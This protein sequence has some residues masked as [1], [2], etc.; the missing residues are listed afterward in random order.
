MVQKAHRKSFKGYLPTNK[1][2]ANILSSQSPEK[3][4]WLTCQDEHVAWKENTE[5]YAY[6]SPE[7]GEKRLCQAM[8]IAA[9]NDVKLGD[10]HE[11]LS[12]WRYIEDIVPGSDE[13]LLSFRHCCE[14]LKMCHKQVRESIKSLVR[15]RK[16]KYL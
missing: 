13:Y 12:A 7:S 2:A 11:K 8:I 5:L 9:I 3:W 6:Q 10:R 4:D 1:K 15:V 16:S 14:E